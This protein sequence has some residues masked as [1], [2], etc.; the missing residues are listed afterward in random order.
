[1][2]TNQEYEVAYLLVRKITCFVESID[3]DSDCNMKLYKYFE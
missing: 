3:N 2:V 1:M